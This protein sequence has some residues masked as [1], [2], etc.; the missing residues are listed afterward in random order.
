MPSASFSSNT[1]LFYGEL[2]SIAT[3]VLQGAF[4]SAIIGGLIGLYIL[5]QLRSLYK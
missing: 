2:V 1:L 4:V 3:S 5:F